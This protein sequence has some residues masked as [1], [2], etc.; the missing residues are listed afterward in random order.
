MDVNRKSM[1]SFGRET[2][3]DGPEPVIFKSRLGPPNVRI[4][5]FGEFEIEAHAHIL[6]EHSQFFGLLRAS[7]KDGEFYRKGL[8]WF[9]E[10]RMDVD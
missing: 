6:E 5:L 2:P 3:E 8:F 4:T 9:V 1:L 7:T 10:P